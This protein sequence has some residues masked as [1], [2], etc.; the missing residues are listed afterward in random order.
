MSALELAGRL[1]P[2]FVE[3]I[4]VA[5]RGGKDPEVELRAMMS[6]AE[7]QAREFERRKFGP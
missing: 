3:W 4:G 6:T 7:T 2:L 1:L 5:L